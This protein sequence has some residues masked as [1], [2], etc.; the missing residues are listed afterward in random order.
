MEWQRKTRSFFLCTFLSVAYLIK[1]YCKFF[2]FCVFFLYFCTVNYNFELN[3]HKIDMGFLKSL[4]GVTDDNA[5]DEKKQSADKDF[6][7]LKNDGIRALRQCQC[8]ADYAV[9]CFEHALAIKDDAEVREQ[10]A[11][12]L[13]QLG[14]Y[15]QS[16]EQYGKLVEL[17]PDNAALIMRKA[18]MA[19]LADEYDVVTTDCAR[20][21]ELQ[22]DNSRACLLYARGYMGNGNDIPAIAMLTKAIALDADNLDAYLLR[23]Q[24]LLKLG[25]SNGAKEDAEKLVAEAPDS[26]EAQLLL[27]RVNEALGNHEEAIS[28]YNKVVDLNPFSVEAFRERGAVK[29][30]M[31]DKEGAE[32]DMRQVLEI[33]PDTLDGTTGDFTAEGREGIQCKVEQA[34]KNI[35]P[36]GL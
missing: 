35:N 7:I 24:Q 23:G 25:D 31:G 3:T 36:L 19:Y 9:K 4:F 10:L 12:A 27:A 6:E 14:E 11:V 30:A 33:A 15:A 1:R 26:E 29:L 34:Y 2:V 16:A 5:A 18:E 28:I 8:N 13:Y 21:L 32:A 17:E 20:I 22:P